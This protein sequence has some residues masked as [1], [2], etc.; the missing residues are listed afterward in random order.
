MSLISAAA[1]ADPKLE[2]DRLNPLDLRRMTA[3]YPVSPLLVLMAF[4]ACLLVSG[5]LI[6][7]QFIGI[8]NAYHSELVVLSGAV[9]QQIQLGFGFDVPVAIAANRGNRWRFAIGGLVVLAVFCILLA[10][11]GI[12]PN[13]VVLYFG[14]YLAISMSGALTSTQHGA[15]ANYYPAEVRTRAIMA[16]R[17]VGVTAIAL[18]A[19]IA[20]AFGKGFAWQ[21]PFFGLAGLALV[22][23]FVGS[24]LLP[25]KREET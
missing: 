10:M 6:V 25:V 14:V 20:F 19:P 21:A 2:R 16:H 11:G 17:F 22:L 15:L 9:A 24:R 4:N 12:T 8:Q 23:A 3:P 13:T 1:V 7:L 18:A 5:A